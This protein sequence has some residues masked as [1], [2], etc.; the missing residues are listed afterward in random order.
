[1]VAR[2]PS[3]CLQIRLCL[4]APRVQGAATP[5]SVTAQTSRPTKRTL[6]KRFSWKVLPRQVEAILAPQPKL[7]RRI[8]CMNRDC[9]MPV[10]RSFGAAATMEPEQ[11]FEAGEGAKAV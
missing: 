6:Q 11:Y 7:W 9:R 1:M 10:G 4:D 3:R 8:F 5:E 2:R